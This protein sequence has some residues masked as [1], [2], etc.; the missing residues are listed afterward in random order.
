MLRLNL[1]TKLNHGIEKLFM[2]AS[3]ILLVTFSSIVFIQIIFRNIFKIPM[4]WSIEVSLLC[5]F[6]AV[7]LGAA[8]GLRYRRHYTVELLPESFVRTNL[9]LD[10][11]SH[12]IVLVLIYI[13]VVHGYRFAAMGFSKMSTSIAMPQ[14]Y[15][16]LSLPV[17]G[18]AMVLFSLELLINDIKELSNLV[19]GGN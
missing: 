4:M 17:G 19:K 1:L 3:V 14:G 15:F 9:I 16:F 18:A 10:I 12:L 11:I 13:F 2:F 5:F 8:V 7:F 6:W